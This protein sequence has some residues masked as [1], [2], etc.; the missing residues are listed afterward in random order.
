MTL[1]SKLR[2]G[3][4]SDIHLEHR[5]N[6][7]HEIIANLDNEISDEILSGLDILV[8]AGDVFDDLAVVNSPGLTDVD[9]WIR[10]LLRKCKKHDVVV[11]V[12]EGTPGHDWKQSTRFET[13]NKLA[14]IGAELRYFDDLTVWYEERF[15]KNFLFVPDEWGDKDPANTLTAVKD[16]LKAK[17]LEQVDFAIMH[18]QFDYQMP[19]F[20]KIRSHDSNEYLKLVK[21]LIFIGHVHTYSRKDRIIA[22]GSFDRLVHGEEEPKGWVIADVDFVNNEYDIQFREN[23]GAKTFKT[24]NCIGKTTEEILEIVDRLVINLRDGSHVRIEAEDF[25]PIFAHWEVLAV[26]HPL[27]QWKKLARTK[28]DEKSA[29]KALQE[30]DEVY[31]PIIISQD[32]VR[33]LLME[34]LSRRTEESDIINCAARLLDEVI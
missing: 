19:E 1:V 10:R 4:A 29:E 23:K 32:N 20:I 25:N 18:G 11:Y 27:I 34:R 17:G 5:V 2:I 31:V 7:T 8:F 30:E 14:D 26:R 24:I 15:D 13:V 12:L 3:S 6:P 28:E 22:Q 33:G 16:L 21:H 9:F